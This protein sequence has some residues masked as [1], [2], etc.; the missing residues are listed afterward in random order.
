MSEARPE[1]ELH[2]KP[3]PEYEMKLLVAL[4]AFL[5]R[6]TAPQ[7]GACL[8]M[9]LRQSCDRILTQCEY[10]G[11][12]WG[13]DKWQV[14]DYIYNQPEAAKQRIAAS[15][16]VHYPDEPDVFTGI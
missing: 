14:L 7:A 1:R 10:Y 6:E 13:M 16:Q 3:L 15:G 2:L 9:Y 8:A 12:Q 4:A 5:G 11:H